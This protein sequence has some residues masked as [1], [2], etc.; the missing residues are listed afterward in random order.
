MQ[1][2]SELLRDISV[3]EVRV[4]QSLF[5]MS[6]YVLRAFMH[7]SMPCFLSPVGVGAFLVRRLRNRLL[8]AMNGNVEVLAL[9]Q[10]LDGSCRRLLW[11]RARASRHLRKWMLCRFRILGLSTFGCQD[12]TATSAGVGHVVLRR[13]GGA[14]F[15]RSRPQQ[16]TSACPASQPY[17]A[18]PLGMVVQSESRRGVVATGGIASQSSYQQPRYE[19]LEALKNSRGPE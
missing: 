10:G 19:S 14:S 8:H 6:Q 11:P 9:E 3:D 2:Y 17:E 13:C 5:C 4:A 7:G 18:D 1:L 15:R 16:L 12:P